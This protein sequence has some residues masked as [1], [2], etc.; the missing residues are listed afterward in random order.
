MSVLSMVMLIASIFFLYLVI[1]N[2][3]KNNIGPKI[4]PFAANEIAIPAAIILNVP[5]INESPIP[6]KGPINDVLTEFITLSSKFS[7]F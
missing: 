5:G 6:A 2:I 1:R 4:L 7:L 3:N